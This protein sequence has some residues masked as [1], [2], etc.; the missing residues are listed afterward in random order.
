MTY[1]ITILGKI[2]CQTTAPLRRIHCLIK[3][4]VM[5][6]YWGVEV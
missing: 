4:H 5:K 2:T 3:Q 1:A 6:T